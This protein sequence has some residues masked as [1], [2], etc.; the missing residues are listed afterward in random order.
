MEIKIWNQSSLEN[1]FLNN[2][3]KTPIVNGPVAHFREA[4]T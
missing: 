3:L 1:N 2:W 4:N